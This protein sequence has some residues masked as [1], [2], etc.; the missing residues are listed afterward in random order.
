MKAI[1]S[2]LAKHMR[3]I[4][5]GLEAARKDGDATFLGVIGPYAA[6]ASARVA[7]IDRDNEELIRGIAKVVTYLGEDA[8]LV[9]EPETG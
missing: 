7:Q 8:K 4:D 6:D 5:K 2:E 1:L 9:E 3:T